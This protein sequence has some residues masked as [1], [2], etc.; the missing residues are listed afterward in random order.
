MAIWVW[1]ED[2]QKLLIVNGLRTVRGR[3]DSQV[4]R[5]FGLL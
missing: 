1:Q 4:K 3:Y 5:R 2:P